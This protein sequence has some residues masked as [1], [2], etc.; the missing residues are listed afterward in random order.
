MHLTMA[1][2][3]HTNPDREK[4]EQ[5]LVRLYGVELTRRMLRVPA[6]VA[7]LDALSACAGKTSDLLAALVWQSVMSV[8]ILPAELR[9]DVYEATLGAA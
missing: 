4:H 6:F 2:S 9:G 1:P 3:A 8:G 7:R 5:L